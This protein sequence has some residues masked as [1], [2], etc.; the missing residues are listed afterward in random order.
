[1]SRN[2]WGAIDLAGKK[3]LSCL[4]SDIVRPLGTI[5][6]TTWTGEQ[7]IKFGLDANTSL[8]GRQCTLNLRVQAGMVATTS[9]T[10]TYGIVPIGY[11]AQDGTLQDGTKPS[12]TM[13]RNWLLSNFNY[14]TVSVNGVTLDTCKYPAIVKTCNDVVFG[15]QGKVSAGDAIPIPL[16]KV[17]TIVNN[18]T[19]L[20]GAYDTSDNAT[21]WSLNQDDPE[22]QQQTNG[23]LQAQTEAILQCHLPFSIF[24]SEEMLPGGVEVQIN[25]S[26]NGSYRQLFLD[27]VGPYP[28]KPIVAYNQLVS[29]VGNI[30][31]VGVSVVDFWLNRVS[32]RD[33]SL[34]GLSKELYFLSYFYQ[35]QS[36]QSSNFTYNM[37]IPKG[38]RKLAFF[39][40]SNNRGGVVKTDALG[41]T[42]ET[43]F[44][45]DLSSTRANMLNPVSCIQSLSLRWNGQVLP[46]IQYNMAGVLATADGNAPAYPPPSVVSI[47]TIRAYQD[48]LNNSS[49]LVDRM[50]P[51]MFDVMTWMKQPVFMF[52]LPNGE[53]L[54]E[55]NCEVLYQ[56]KGNSAGFGQ[57]SSIACIA[58]SLRSCSVHVHGGGQPSTVG[59]MNTLA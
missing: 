2:Q 8:I 15:A 19:C 1:M 30:G 9:A 22:Y 48:F 28:T 57:Q 40:L 33:D 29:A 4:R 6:D 31:Q 49:S 37:S 25:F 3:H 24:E 18:S 34:I 54:A 38:T 11:G 44:N 56:A 46:S 50:A 16:K 58:Y 17:S 35:N 5:S 12:N 53:T 45:T 14:V 42:S 32:I 13:A 43:N 52:M 41:S 26:I 36:I 47:D 27:S 20:I 55:S 39:F 10:P 21:I 51:A 59:E 7:V 23:L